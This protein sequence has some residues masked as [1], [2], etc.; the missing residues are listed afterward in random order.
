MASEA[1]KKKKAEAA[2]TGVKQKFTFFDVIIYVLI[3]LLAIICLYPFLNV[4]AISLSGYNAVLSN[5]VFFIPKDVTVAA[6]Q[7]IIARPQIWE[8]MGTT[9]IVTVSGTAIGLVLTTAA[10]Y[11]LSRNYLPGRKVFSGLILFTMYFSGG[12]IPTFL[13]VKGVGMF[14]PSSVN[15][16]S[17][18]K[19]QHRSMAQTRCRPCSRS[20]CL[21]PFRSLQQLVCS[22]QYSIGM[23]ISRH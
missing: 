10:A 1:K 18:W 6:Y 23:I 8:A 17:S 9:V 13:V 4:L 2:S 22:T 20:S 21:C 15:F 3:A 11:A 5:S 12:I 16:R 14:D 7:N 19:K